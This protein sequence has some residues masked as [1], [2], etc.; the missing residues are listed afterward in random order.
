MTKII[1][2]LTTG[3]SKIIIRGMPTSTAIRP[4][5]SDRKKNVPQW[6]EEGYVCPSDWWRPCTKRAPEWKLA[7]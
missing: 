3:S 2:T 4:V 1:N 6:G 5:T 7:A